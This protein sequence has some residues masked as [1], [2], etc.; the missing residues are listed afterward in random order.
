MT[1]E[2]TANRQSSNKGGDSLRTNPSDGS[3]EIPGSNLAMAPESSRDTD[4]ALP[5]LPSKRQSVSQPARLSESSNRAR[6]SRNQRWLSHYPDSM[7]A[8][9]HAHRRTGSTLRTVMRKIFTRKGRSQTDGSDDVHEFNFGNHGSGERGSAA[10]QNSEPQL[11]PPH[12]DD[13]H[14]VEEAGRDRLEPSRRSRR[15]TLPSVVLSERESREAVDGAVSPN[16]GATDRIGYHS[17]PSQDSLR[18][19][20][21]M[22]ARRRSRSANAPRVTDGHVSPMQRRRSAGP[23]SAP[24]GMVSDSEVSFRPPTSSTA[25]SAVEESIASTSDTEQESIAPNVSYLVNSMQNDENASLEQRLTTLEIKLVDLELAMAR[26][27]TQ[28]GPSPSGDKARRKKSPNPDSDRKHA[29][30]DTSDSSPPVESSTSPQ[31]TDADRRLSAATVRPNE[32][33]GARTL[34]VPSSSSLTDYNGI[35]IEQYSALV[36]LL[37]REQ[38]ARRNLESQVS[39][40]R[41]DMQQLRRVARD[42]M[43]VGVGVGTMYPIISKDSQEYLGAHT[44]SRDMSVSTSG[45]SPRGERIAPPYDIDSDW[46]YPQDEIGRAQWERGQ[47]IE[48]AGMI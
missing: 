48:I 5:Q 15:A 43:S 24:L 25:T 31:D 45:T 10:K 34:Q 9:D 33:H 4:T 2:T 28:K 19:S 38:S 40:L 36:M 14:P 37:R 32:P 27:Q 11:S 23:L 7:A 26:M 1:L 6:D 13:S 35:S 12:K 21:Q 42:S 17:N 3:Q 46:D 16:S 29:R 41:D 39:G 22:A 8:A 30:K 18:R 47:R 44:R 20:G